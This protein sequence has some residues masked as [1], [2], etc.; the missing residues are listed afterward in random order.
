MSSIEERRAQS[1]RALAVAR[2]S[3]PLKFTYGAPKAVKVRPKVERTAETR[4]YF[5][6]YM[7][8]RR[9][10]QKADASTNLHGAPS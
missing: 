9:A 6:D 8:E 5:R 3:R 7:R 10:R 4:A 2:L 1:S